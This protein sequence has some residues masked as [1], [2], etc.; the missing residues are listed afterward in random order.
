MF[1]ECCVTKILLWQS[2][3]SARSLVVF[4]RES[5]PCWRQ[6]SSWALY[7][8]DSIKKDNDGKETV[9]FGI[10]LQNAVWR[11]I[12]GFFGTLIRMPLHFKCYCTAQE[13]QC[14]AHST[15]GNER[16]VTKWF[17]HL[18]LDCALFSV[19]GTMLSTIY[20]GCVTVLHNSDSD[21][22]M[23]VKLSNYLIFWHLFLKRYIFYERGLFCVPYTI[24]NKPLFMLS[25]EFVYKMFLFID[26]H[27]FLDFL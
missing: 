17:P 1:V 15:L 20:R 12:P 24:L 26:I 11:G 16:L 10:V 5:F 23:L 21:R 19:T 25:W 14:I 13:V 8:S 18:L 9:A 27:T 3:C 4:K 2:L 7:P 6:A 22:L